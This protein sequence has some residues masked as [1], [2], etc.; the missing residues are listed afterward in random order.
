M[1]ASGTGWHCAVG[2]RACT[3]GSRQLP[4]S[5]CGRPS[6]CLCAASPRPA[7]AECCL[8]CRLLQLQPANKQQ[9]INHSNLFRSQPVPPMRQLNC[10]SS[11]G[12]LRIAS[13]LPLKHHGQTPTQQTFYILHRSSALPAG[14]V[15]APGQEGPSRGSRAG[16][17]TP[18]SAQP[19]CSR[20]LRSPARRLP[21]MA[22]HLQGQG[23]WTAVAVDAVGLV[24]GEDSP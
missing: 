13:L 9:A 3:A 8:L 18:L 14:H 2:H 16:G 11:M 21:S 22:M 19:P 15:A 4:A 6:S 10:H 17:V 12:N 23:Y 7:P 1:L 24:T 20:A 5:P